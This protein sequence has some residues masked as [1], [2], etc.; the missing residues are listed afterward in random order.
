MNVADQAAEYLK[1][2][3]RE[4]VEITEDTHS[5]DVFDD[6][7]AAR[8]AAVPPTEEYMQARAK[9]GRTNATTTPTQ[10]TDV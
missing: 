7:A 4:T 10:D 6:I 3:T 9:L 8:A 5:R 2:R 1:I